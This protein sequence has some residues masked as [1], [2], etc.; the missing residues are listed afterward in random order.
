MQLSKTRG[1]VENP[2]VVCMIGHYNNR[3]QRMLLQLGFSF[4]DCRYD[5]IG[6][7]RILEPQ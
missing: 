2:F 1:L 6:D 4:A 3:A 5:E 7:N